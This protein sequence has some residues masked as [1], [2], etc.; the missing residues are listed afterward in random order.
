MQRKKTFDSFRRCKVVILSS[1]TFPLTAPDWAKAVLQFSFIGYN[2]L[3]EG[4]KGR[5]KVDV[6]LAPS[7]ANLKHHD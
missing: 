6:K 5:N 4:V 2:T 1:R 7:V 3:E